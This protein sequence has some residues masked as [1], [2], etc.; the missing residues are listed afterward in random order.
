MIAVIST[1]TMPEIRELIILSSAG[2][3]LM[4]LEMLNT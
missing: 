3:K 4:Q 1:K 2:S